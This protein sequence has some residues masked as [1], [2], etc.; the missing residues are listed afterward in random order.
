M[1]LGEDG[2]PTDDV[3][4][5]LATPDQVRRYEAAADQLYRFQAPTLLDRNDPHSHLLIGLL[6]GTGNDV[7]QDPL[8]A[9]NVAKL[10]A[11]ARDLYDAGVEGVHVEYSPGPGTQTNTI[12]KNIDGATG[13]TSLERAEEMYGK[14]VE[15]AQRIFKA[16]PDAQL[17]IYLE[18]FSRG[19]SEAPLVARMI[20]ERGIPAKDSV[21]DSVDELGHP[22]KSYTRYLQSPGMTPMAVGL[23]DPVPTGYMEVFDR[24]LPPSVVSGFQINAAD[25]RRGLF[26]VDRILPDGLSEDGRF[27]SVTVSGVHSDIGGSYLRGGLGGRSLNLM[28]DYRNALSSEP[29]FQRLHETQDARM[30]VIHHST[31]GSVLFRHF[32]KIGRD[33]PQGEITQLVPDHSHLAAPGQ[34]V[35]VVKQAPEPVDESLL[36]GVSHGRTVVRSPLAPEPAMP[37]GEA[38]LARVMDSPNVELRAYQPPMPLPMKVTFGVAAAGGVLSVVEAAAAGDRAAAQLTLDNPEA[39]KSVLAHYG[40]RGLG[41]WAGGAVTGAA[42]GWETGPGAMVF[43]ATGAVAGSSIGDRFARLQDNHAIF[44]Q[45]DAAGVPWAFNGRAWERQGLVDATLDATDNPARTAV[46]ASYDKARELNCR[47]TNTATA[48]A[49]GEA[50]PPANPFRLPADEH[51]RGSLKPAPW[52]FDADGGQWHRRVVVGADRNDLDIVEVETASPERAASLSRASLEVMQ[53]NVVNGPAGIAAR[54]EAAYTQYGWEKFGPM[55]EAVRTALTDH[56]RLIA[57]DGKLYER[58]PDGDWIH[59]TAIPGNDHAEGALRL[60]LNASRVLLQANLQRHAEEISTALPHGPKT[61]EATQHEELMYRYRVAGTEL[62]PEWREAIDLAMQ[63]T[64]TENALS[65]PGS[66]QLKPGPDGRIGADSPIVHLQ[67]DREGVDHIAAVTS[68][69]DIRQALAEVRARHEVPVPG[70][71]D[72]RIERATEQERDAHV[73]AMREANRQG[74]AQPETAALETIQVTGR[75]R[76]DGVAREPVDA[77]DTPSPIAEASTRAPDVAPVP[78]PEPELRTPAVS[79]A[80]RV[81]TSAPD[82]ALRPGTRGD[83]VELLQFRLDRQGYRGPE[84]EPLPQDGH[85]GPETEH[86]VRQFQTAHALPA[87]GIADPDTQ[88]AVARA[89]SP[90][91]APVEH[92]E[93]VATPSPEPTRDAFERTVPP[94][95][96]EVAATQKEARPNDAVPLISPA[97]PKLAAGANKPERD[98]EREVA[99]PG[100]EPRAATG[101]TASTHPAHGLYLQSQRAME[102]VDAAPGMAGLSERERETLGAAVVAQAVSTPGWNF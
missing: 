24:R 88:T 58:Q 4:H 34:V 85:Y 40:G 81:D 67:R 72:Q 62:Q 42:L 50:E 52:T 28:T 80:P 99:E 94:P 57:S 86:A 47:A 63:R 101:M 41:G 44:H 43:I 70:A 21:I 9:T 31:E 36:R 3:P 102:K 78:S 29:L 65:G 20:H 16:D 17:S 54:Y 38:M 96:H 13:R 5:T 22:T 30:N 56:D 12:A 23:Y 69:E 90:Q 100:R 61:A 84:G 45:S 48:L 39:A 6:D 27:L 32:P 18:G 49:L 75:R 35:T 93:P 59:R 83:Q 92:A 76:D 91:R 26:P 64:R 95:A 51:D 77:L 7:D 60:E 37:A 15:N 98:D 74:L 68:S 89:P 25:E 2:L 73:Q 11:Q 79:T 71:P 10:R 87:T 53:A 14:L 46:V 33:T 66:V 55:P 8:H 19:A 82:D 97:A 1:R